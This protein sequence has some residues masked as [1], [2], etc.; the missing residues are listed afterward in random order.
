MTDS[1]PTM[2]LLVSGLL[3][4]GSSAV[5]DAL[6]QSDNV[7]ALSG[8]FKFFS[9]WVA[10]RYAVLSILHN[11]IGS[12][13]AF[14]QAAYDLMS[15]RMRVSRLPGGYYRKKLRGIRRIAA[16]VALP[17]LGPGAIRR[18]VNG[19]GM[20]TPVGSAEML[21]S[22]LAQRTSRR[23]RQEARWHRFT[24]DGFWATASEAAERL[25]AQIAH[26]RRYIVCDQAVPVLARDLPHES[27]DG[28]AF[29]K[30]SVQ[31]VVYRDPA[32]QLSD[33]MVKGGRPQWERVFASRIANYEGTETERFCKWQI[34]SLELLHDLARRNP[35][36]VIPVRFEDF[37]TRYA[38]WRTNIA[39][40]IDLD[41]PAGGGTGFDPGRSVKNIGIHKDILA[42]DQRASIDRLRP[43]FEQLWQNLDLAGRASIAAGNRV[44]EP[45]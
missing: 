34:D 27:P 19:L 11:E 26:G 35:G 6:S 43:R 45:D 9:H 39:S 44:G 41:L 32:D 5:V 21:S 31:F 4:S 42:A 8:E 25:L 1:K 7:V 24:V 15:L 16:I 33:F 20:R 10:P 18:V 30:D 38:T 36:R 40:M 29:Y 12:S 37:V 22:H 14:Y 13:E 28:L 2:P 3:W 23:L 17:F